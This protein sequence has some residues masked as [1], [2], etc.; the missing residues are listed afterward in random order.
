MRPL[1]LA[2]TL[3]ALFAATLGATQAADVYVPPPAYGVAPPPTY[4]PPPRYGY[5]PGYGPPPV[6]AYAPPPGVIA[7]PQGPAYIV[8]QPAYQAGDEYVQTPV[9][10]GP[11]HYRACWFEWGQLRCIVRPRWW[12]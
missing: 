2:C 12:W 10:V 6:V 3:A 4:V 7:V 5:A 9:L 8:S 1:M 11:Q